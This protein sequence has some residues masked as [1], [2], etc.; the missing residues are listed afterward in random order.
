RQIRAQVC[1]PVSLA[2]RSHARNVSRRFFAPG[3]S[4]TRR[5]GIGN[6]YPDK[7][8]AFFASVVPGIDT[9]HF[10]VLIRSQRRNH[11]TPPAPR[12]KP[13]AVVAALHL[14]TVKS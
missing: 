10:Q 14:L 6:K 12:V 13:P 2:E 5:T 11:L 9:I 7:L 8:I 1:A 3:K 4:R